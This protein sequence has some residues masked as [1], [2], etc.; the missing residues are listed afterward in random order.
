MSPELYIACVDLDL[1]VESRKLPEQERDFY[2]S[3][4]RYKRMEAFKAA[5]RNLES[6]AA[7]GNRAENVLLSFSDPTPAPIEAATTK[8]ACGA[9]PG[10]LPGSASGKI[11]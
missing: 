1:H 7:R 8:A 11:S 3:Q 4:Q 2:I 9:Y 10:N 6:G 5:L